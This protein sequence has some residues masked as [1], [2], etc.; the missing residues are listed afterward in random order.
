MFN[1][2]ILIGKK[3]HLDS[4]LSSRN[5]LLLSFVPVII[6]TGFLSTLVGLQLMNKNILPQIQDQV[7]LELYSGHELFNASVFDVR[8]KV[9]LIAE[10]AFIRDPFLKRNLEKALPLLKEIRRKESLDFL[11]ITDAQGKVIIRTTN[12][13]ETSENQALEGLRRRVFSGR[14]DVGSVEI[15]KKENLLVENSELVQKAYTKVV[16]TFFSRFND[17]NDNNEDVGGMVIVAAAPILNE[18]EEIIGALY[19]GRLVNHNSDLV[20][21]M[22]SA[23][24]GNEHYKGKGLGVVTIFQNGVRIATTMTNENGTRAE[25]QLISEKV[26]DRV[27]V[28]GEKYIDRAFIV[29]DW[30]L[31]AYEPIK[32]S[33]G[34][35]IGVLGI[36]LLEN[37]FR[38]AQ[39]NAMLT[40][41]VISFLIVA[42]A[43]YICFLLAKSI[44]KPIN[45][46]QS[47]T[48]KL[49]GGNFE[50]RVNLRNSSKEIMELG[51]AFNY[52]VTSIKERDELLKRQTQEDLMNAERLAMIGRL[53]AGIAHEINNP[54]GSILLFSRLLLQ[55]APAEGLMRD[56]LERIEKDTKRCQNIVQGLLDFARQREPKIERVNVNDILEKTTMLFHNHP[57]FHNIEIVKQYQPDISAVSADSSQI[58]QV[59]VNIFMN[60]VDAMEGTGVLTI[61]TRSIAINKTVEISIADTGCGISPEMINKI[62]EPFFTTKPVGQGTG[63]GLSISYGIIHQHGGTIKALSGSG[64]GTTFVISLPVLEGKA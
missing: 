38:D 55:K 40:F 52:M 15:F 56:N 11:T 41:L 2:I 25:G 46:L 3:L 17:N 14:T 30:Y 32:N 24:Y 4:S 10:K 43:G 63:L 31:S 54:L 61:G 44:V 34:A 8:E 7:K 50:H 6:M 53:A 22:Q 64:E 48:K 26:R 39:K 58:M 59:F 51:D 16:P 37:K 5:K 33:S 28:R 9:K 36:G 23:L 60:A 19:A 42:V 27:I 12:P 1:R 18:K 57:L 20:D 62:F 49:A 29:D 45:A 35:S 21:S 13:E 47:A